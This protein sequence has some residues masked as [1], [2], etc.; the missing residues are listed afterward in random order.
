MIFTETFHF[1]LLNEPIGVL[2]APTMTTSLPLQFLV[3]V[4]NPLHSPCLTRHDDKELRL[5]MAMEGSF[6]DEQIR[7][8]NIQT[9]AALVACA[10]FWTS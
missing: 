8:I 7:F 5:C 4:E 2:A 6:P 3:V 1:Y 10:N 9:D